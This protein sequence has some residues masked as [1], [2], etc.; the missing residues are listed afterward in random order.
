MQ[1]TYK[2][3]QRRTDI[4]RGFHQR[5][6]EAQIVQVHPLAD[7][8]SEV[9]AAGSGRAIFHK[10]AAGGVRNHIAWVVETICGKARI[11]QRLSWIDPEV[12]KDGENLGRSAGAECR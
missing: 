2:A 1:E 3:A 5:A 7:Q 4:P 6:Q 8:K 10:A 11:G 9:L 12:F